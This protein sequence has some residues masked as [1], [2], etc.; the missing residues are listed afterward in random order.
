MTENLFEAGGIDLPPEADPSKD[1]LTELVGDGKKFKDQAALARGKYEADQYIEILKREKDAM[2]SEYLK[3]RDENMTKANLQEI[4]DQIK[5]ERL[6][7]SDTTTAKEVDEQPKVNPEEIET[8]IERKM[9][10]RESA[11]KQSEN[12]SLVQKKLKEQWGTNYASVLKQQTE[13]LGLDD[14]FVNQLAKT[15]PNVLFKTLGFD[16]QTKDNLFQTPPR[17]N[18]RSDNF[19]PRGAEKRTW[20]Y[21]QDLMKKD[22]NLRFDRQLSVQMQRDA[23]EMGEAFR[24]GDYYVKGLHE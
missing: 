23:I 17:S 9:E 14:E 24:D 15:N 12:F 4:I 13:S 18:Q 7:S 10:A 5:K 8:L 21:Y 2:R 6:T 19:A 22:P 3:L 20:S 1:Y 11:K 16:Q